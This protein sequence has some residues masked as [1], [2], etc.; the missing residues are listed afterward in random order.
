MSLENAPH[1]AGPDPH[2]AGVG[3]AQSQGQPAQSRE[4]T[5]TEMVLWIQDATTEDLLRKWRFEP[6][7]SPW[8]RGPVGLAF[9]MEI[10]KRRTDDPVGWSQ[11]S[12]RV[13]WEAR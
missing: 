10:G 1:G 13:G 8:F 3:D 12:K 6:C 2:G 4:M 7:G 11:A 9:A 5:R